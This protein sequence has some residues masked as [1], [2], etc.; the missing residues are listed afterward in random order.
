MYRKNITTID[1]GVQTNK[2]NDKTWGQEIYLLVS[3]SLN[4]YFS[5]VLS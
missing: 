4:I 2:I 5:I 3:R 1:K